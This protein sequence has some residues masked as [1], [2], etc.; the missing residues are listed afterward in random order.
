MREIPSN[1][2]II[3]HDDHHDD[4]IIVM[5]AEIEIVFWVLPIEVP[6]IDFWEVR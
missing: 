2:N 4:Y 5:S 3:S 1:R 6:P